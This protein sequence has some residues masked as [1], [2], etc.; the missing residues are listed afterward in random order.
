MPMSRRLLLLVACLFSLEAFGG[1][2]GTTPPPQPAN[3]D[4][5]KEPVTPEEALSGALDWLAAAQKKDGSWEG[6]AGR[7]GPA[8]GVR[9][10][11]IALMA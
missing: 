2:P 1:E 10:T 6:V 11:T 9:T 4:K 8:A 3:P 7:R 5:S